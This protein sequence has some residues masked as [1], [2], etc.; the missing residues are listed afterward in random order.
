[1]NEMLPGH[2]DNFFIHF[3]SDSPLPIVSTDHQ[4]TREWR[5]R[6]NYQVTSIQQFSSLYRRNDT[7]R[8]FHNMC[9]TAAFGA[10]LCRLLASVRKISIAPCTLRILM[11][12]VHHV[13]LSRPPPPRTPTICSP[14][15][16]GTRTY[17]SCCICSPRIPTSA[18]GAPSPGAPGHSSKR[19]P[20]RVSFLCLFV[21]VASRQLSLK[22]LS[23][24]V[25]VQPSSFQ[26]LATTWTYSVCELQFQ[27]LAMTDAIDGQ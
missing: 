23:F 5:W 12:S 18:P 20:W 15:I 22:Q 27:L 17:R 7:A 26:H 6:Y 19:P 9:R 25:H 13:I 3:K 10:V 21:S 1:M 2:N 24:R 4:T 14:G 11:H 8:H 16:R